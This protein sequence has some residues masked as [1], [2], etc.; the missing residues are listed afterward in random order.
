MIIGCNTADKIQKSSVRLFKQACSFRAI[1]YQP[2]MRKVN[3]FRSFQSMNVLYWDKHIPLGFPAEGIHYAFGLMKCPHWN[4]IVAYF[5]VVPH[6][7]FEQYSETLT[8]MQ[9]HIISPSLPS[10]FVLM[11]VKLLIWLQVIPMKVN[12]VQTSMQ[13]MYGENMK[14]WTMNWLFQSMGNTSD[15]PE[16]N[17]M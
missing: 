16:K 5:D 10:I 8:L 17:Y 9:C 11:L 1:W 4:L 6:H 14:Q 7:V 2:G 3:N 15:L 12:W 13:V